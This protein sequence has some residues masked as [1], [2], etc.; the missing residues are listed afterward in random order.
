MTRCFIMLLLA[1][2]AS[3]A[4]QDRYS[5][6][7]GAPRWS[8]ADIE[9]FIAD[10]GLEE[11]G[12]AA[13]IRSLY[14][15][16]V[17]SH[18]QAR[19]AYAEQLRLAYEAQQR[20]R[21][22][23]PGVRDPTYELGMDFGRQRANLEYFRQF[24]ALE[25]EFLDTVQSVLA[26][27]TRAA[28]I[29]RRRDLHRRHVFRDMQASG[30]YA[31]ARSLCDLVQVV[32]A[33]QLSD[34]RLKSAA[35]TLDEYRAE[36]SDVV[37]DIRERSL[38]WQEEIAAAGIPPGLR[39]SQAAA[40][41]PKYLD[42][43]EQSFRMTEELAQVNDSFIPRIA[44]ALEEDDRARFLESIDRIQYPSVFR[45]C[46]V[47][48]A[49]TQLG[50][51]ALLDAAQQA[52]LQ[53]VWEDYQL[54]RAQLRQRIVQAQRQFETPQRLLEVERKQKEQIARWA[55]TDQEER[56]SYEP[57]LTDHPAQPLFVQSRELAESA[58][59]ELRALFSDPEFAA[60][61]LSIR[62][63]LEWWKE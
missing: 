44:A 41:L 2:T 61:P 14:R 28:W 48:T 56:L 1:F 12:D 33:L 5:Y 11:A 20:W 50:E 49:A 31:G 40:R 38:T 63:A 43:I 53:R 15:D 10:V 46:P 7:T 24:D 57:L 35:L 62:L 26:G 45:V 22:D 16:H 36:M 27:D 17:A 58:S 18:Q 52:E 34:A 39:G 32:E 42:L 13:I 8:Q 60:L 51:S 3:A 59:R 23:N 6:S 21:K 47:E 37:I 29:D 9:Q 25:Y 4:A 30:Y 54:R 19:A 55:L